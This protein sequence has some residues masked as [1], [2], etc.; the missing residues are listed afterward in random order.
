MILV[1]LVALPV[2]VA[3]IVAVARMREELE[4]VLVLTGAG[5]TLVS[6][7]VAASGELEWAPL[8]LRAD[9]P[10]RLFLA[11]V[12]PIF[13]GI[14]VYVW[15]RVDAVPALKEQLP[16]FVPASL[17]LL[18]AVDLVFIA[19][20]LVLAWL[21]LEASTFAAA[22]LVIRRAHRASLL[23]SW[24]YLV[25][26]GVA[27]S[28]TFL[29]FTLVSRSLGAHDLPADFSLAALEGLAT[30]TTDD[31]GR[32]GVL[33]LLLGL[34][35]KLGLA[36]M[37]SWLPETYDEAPPATVALLAS[38]QFN[39][40]LLVLV[41]VV[42]AFG[43]AHA[44]LIVMVLLGLGLASVAVSTAGVVATRSFKRLVA[45]A[46]I[47][48]AGVIAIGLGIGGEAAY[49]LFL[50]VMSNA[51]TKAI[52]F[53]TVGK[54][55]AHYHTKDARQVTGLLQNL[56]YSAIF[57][58]VGTFALLG[59]PPFGSFFGELL[60][61]SGLASGEHMT[62]FVV[63]CVLITMTFVATGRTIFPMIWGEGTQPAN[64]PKQTLWSSWPKAVFF[65][66]LVVLGLYIPS[67]ANELIHSVAALVGSQ[68]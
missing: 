17:L 33:V 9:A 48:H 51:F 53:L 45:F 24:S 25:F 39:A 21:A 31:W 67:S 55:K 27:L 54:I 22:P 12:N 36:P 63:F 46:S 7:A 23:A 28:L 16:T 11:F 64:W 30:S 1:L 49:G 59:F 18:A 8:L 4:W 6:W 10:A 5:V 56:P 34:G 29:G 2:V 57:L 20:H 60:I 19:D 26:S 66:A 65:I 52:L 58:M 37:Y 42:H 14:A 50:Y 68:R 43:P 38:V 44:S 35:T 61:L 13:F 32:L 47:N 62:V 15:G 3:A 40:S 41:R